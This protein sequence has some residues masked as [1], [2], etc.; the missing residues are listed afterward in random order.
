MTKRLYDCGNCPAYCCSYEY[1][2]VTDADLARLARHFEL[3]ADTA[4]RRYTKRSRGGKSPFRVL[5]H[6]KDK[7]FGTACQFLDRKTR[8]CGVYEAR[9]TICRTYPGSGRCGFYDF[10]CSERRAQEDPDYIPS[11]TR[12]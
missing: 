2:E 12:G 9:P 6:R 3:D 5:R 4:E 11:F 7:V 8:R 1:I 10:L